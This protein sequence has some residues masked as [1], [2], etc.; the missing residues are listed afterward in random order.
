MHRGQITWRLHA[1]TRSSAAP[2]QFRKSDS[3]PC[4]PIPLCLGFSQMQGTLSKLSKSIYSFILKKN[5]ED[6]FP[7]RECFV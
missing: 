3:L 5:I 4:S 7:N 6:S 2:T 1:T